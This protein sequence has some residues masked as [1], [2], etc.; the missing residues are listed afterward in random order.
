MIKSELAQRISMAS[1]HLYRRDAEKVVNA[2]L[3]E[4]TTAMARGDR[5]ELRGFGSYLAADC[6]DSRARQDGTVLVGQPILGAGNASALNNVLLT[7]SAYF[8]RRHRGR[9]LWN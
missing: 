4:I 9:F 6:A 8:L 3:D 5:V 2:I 7:H 1:P